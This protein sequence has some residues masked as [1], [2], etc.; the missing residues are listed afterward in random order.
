MHISKVDI[1]NDRLLKQTNINCEE[2]LAGIRVH[3]YIEYNEKDNLTNI[4]KLMLDLELQN[5]TV[6]LRF[7]YVLRVF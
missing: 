3:F 1:L 2:D 6:I 4:C 7:E 5:T